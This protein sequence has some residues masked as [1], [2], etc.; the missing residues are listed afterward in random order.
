MEFHTF[1]L[2]M[3]GKQVSDR[4]SVSGHTA[5]PWGT[6]DVD[7]RTFSILISINVLR[8]YSSEKCS[9]TALKVYYNLKRQDF[10]LRDDKA[11]DN[12]QLK[13]IFKKQA[14]LDYR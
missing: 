1:L 11:A 7:H 14:Y 12:R 4:Q 9:P 2:I 8:D 3:G 5:A 10:F 6:T 13:I